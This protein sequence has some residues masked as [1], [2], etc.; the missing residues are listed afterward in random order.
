MT[1]KSVFMQNEKISKRDI[2][3]TVVVIDLRKQ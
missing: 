2:F 3:V 1:L